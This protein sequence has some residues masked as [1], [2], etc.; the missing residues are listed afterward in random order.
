MTCTRIESE[1]HAFIDGELDAARRRVLERHVGECPSCTKLLEE[2][3]AARRAPGVPPVER[4]AV[5]AGQTPANGRP[6]RPPR[7]VAAGFLGAFATSILTVVF[8]GL[9]VRSPE[10]KS[11]RAVPTLSLVVNASRT[12]NLVFASA[13]ALDDVAFTLQL[14]DGVELAGYEGRRR[15]EWRTRLSAGNNVLPLELVAV[16]GR[17]GQLVARLQHG[18][19][20]KVF[21]VNVTVS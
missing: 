13:N 3:K 10:S 8:T 2:A 1:L 18:G 6:G 14:P 12:V 21:V 4:A 20:Q 15:V 17:G 19:M 16:A 9:W 11:D 5:R 7:L